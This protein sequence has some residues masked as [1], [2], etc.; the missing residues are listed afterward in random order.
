MD[1][2]PEFEAVGAILDELRGSS[3]S[4]DPGFFPR[5][6]L[7]DDFLRST[8]MAPVTTNATNLYFGAQKQNEMPASRQ[9]EYLFV[10]AVFCTDI[11]SGNAQL[12]KEDSPIAR[13]SAM[14]HI[15]LQF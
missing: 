1:K 3:W 6:S 12:C 15:I 11:N 14:E 2:I 10:H 9:A 5:S 8:K 4:L 13:N 7:P